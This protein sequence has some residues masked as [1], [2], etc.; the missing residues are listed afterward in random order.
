MRGVWWFAAV[1]LAWRLLEVC[2]GTVM[3]AAPRPWWPALD[4][5]ERATYG[6]AF[7]LMAGRGAARSV[8]AAAGFALANLLLGFLLGSFALRTPL[9]DALTAAM[10]WLA[11][12]GAPL[13]ALALLP[14]ILT[15][16]LVGGLLL[17]AH[18]VARPGSPGLAWIGLH[19]GIGLAWHVGLVGFFL[20]RAYGILPLAATTMVPI[21][22]G[23]MFACAGLHAGLS[24]RRLR[25]E[26]SLPGPR[27][28]LA[29]IGGS[30]LLVTLA[31]LLS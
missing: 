8:A 7:L 14:A 3:A 6:A 30:A 22:T 2:V 16:L 17:L 28:A 18:R 1:L 12:A 21:A 31:K 20:L 13:L 9:G 5:L 24:L 26:G 27:R 29:V 15:G 25:A 10:M 4:G 19:V 11:G 23:W